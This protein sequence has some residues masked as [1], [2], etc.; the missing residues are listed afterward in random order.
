MVK[1]KLNHYRSILLERRKFVLE[2]IERLRE[3]SQISDGDIDLGKRYSDNLADIGSD[4][5]R[6]E[7]SFT[8][9]SR[10]LQY[11]YRIDNALNLINSGRYG[12]CK[13][14]GKEI[15]KARL[16]LVPTTDTCNKCKRL[17]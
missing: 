7:E 11:L 8:F 9:I 12:I 3:L 14:C 16:K 4:S 1:D 5:M 6:R 15:P 13:I 2:T 17:N 10:E